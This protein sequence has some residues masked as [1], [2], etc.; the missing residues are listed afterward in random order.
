M[1]IAIACDHA[2][3]EAKS[4]IAAHLRE[5]GFEV[6]DYGTFSTES[7]DYPDFAEKAGR[8]VA[9]GECEKGVL[10]CGTGV[11]ISI[12][13]NKIK[14]VRCAL[15]NDENAPRYRECIT[16]RTSSPWARG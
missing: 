3:F 1:K 16:T 6:E 14:G 8:A 2:G 13:A 10:I 9:C 12:A 5:K 15:C 11:G 4:A 7:C